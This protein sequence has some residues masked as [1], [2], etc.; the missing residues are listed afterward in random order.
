MENLGLKILGIVLGIILILGLIIGLSCIT[1]VPTG[2]VGVKTRFGKVQN[3]VIQEGLNTKA[4][5]IE[6]IVKIDCKTKKIEQST[7]ASSRDL[8]T[9]TTSIAVNYNVNKDT[10]NT[11]YKEVGTDYEDIIINP[12]MLEAIKQ[13][14]AQ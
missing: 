14:I 10:A 12:A 11:L 13:A 9:V 4:P 1:T 8:Q 2:Y 7:E 5:F 3:D 6:K